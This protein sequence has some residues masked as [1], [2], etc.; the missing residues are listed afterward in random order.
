MISFMREPVNL[1]YF[2]LVKNMLEEGYNGTGHETVEYQKA[3]TW[4]TGIIHEPMTFT[5][6]RQ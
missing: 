5:L 3:M 2:L 4:M 6:H 1:D